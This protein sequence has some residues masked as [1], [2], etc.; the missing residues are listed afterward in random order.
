MGRLL[1]G[2]VIVGVSV[3]AFWGTTALAPAGRPAQRPYVVL[4]H[5]SA[6]TPD[7]V[8]AEQLDRFGGRLEFVYRS[9]I[10]G[11]SARM[12]PTT[13]AALK[14][15]PRVESVTLDEPLGATAQ[16]VPSGLERVEALQSPTAAIDG[17]DR[18]RPDIDVAVLDTGIDRTHPD[19]NVAG[20]YDCTA[21][22]DESK[23]RWVDKVGHGTHIA[24]T[25]GALD[26]GVGVVGVAPGARLWAVR[27]LSDKGEGTTREL[28]CGVDWVASTRGDGD[29]G[30]DIDVAN[31]SLGGKGVDD[32]ACGRQTGDP[33][34]RAVCQAVAAGITF[35]AAAG[36]HAEADPVDERDAARYVPANYDE[37]ITVS[38]LVDSDGRPGGVGGEPR[39]RSGVDDT[40]A[41]FSNYGTDVDLTAPGVCVFS[42][43]PGDGPA[44]RR[45]YGYLSGTSFAAPHVS[46]AAAL[47]LAR[48]PGASPATVQAALLAA[49]RNDWDGSSDPD[50][51]PEP[52]VN[53][54]GF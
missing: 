21:G 5:A 1:A 7:Q 18:P 43:L 33:L 9:A 52:R 49:A 30:N 38:A 25:I 20:G 32:G 35:V 44:G 24:G 36:N 15:D 29:P 17:T 6:G 27:V 28:L 47:Y 13:A 10:S 41:T 2:G 54:A 50:G 51:V 19:L 12:S 23:D 39:C 22:V 53:V 26:D 42:T 34:H 46:G 4:L 14:A 8:A 37:V 40:L 48:N 31:I 16:V 11:Y 45:G 3:G